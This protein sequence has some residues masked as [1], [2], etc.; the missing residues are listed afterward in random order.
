MLSCFLSKK[1]QNLVKGRLNAISLLLLHFVSTG[2]SILTWQSI[3]H[4][5]DVYLNHITF[6]YKSMSNKTL[7]YC[8]FFH[9]MYFYFGTEQ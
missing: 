4:G 3:L 5:V 6:L 8:L 9:N 1:R 7:S 2:F